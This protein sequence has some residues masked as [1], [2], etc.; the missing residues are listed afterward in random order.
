MTY[1]LRTAALIPWAVGWMAGPWAGLTAVANAQ[2]PSAD[3]PLDAPQS[4]GLFE[5]TLS[6][7]ADA[8]VRSGVA[9]SDNFGADAML[10]VRR[11]GDPSGRR[12]TY[13]KFDLAGV[14]TGVVSATLRVHGHYTSDETVVGMVMLGSDNSWTEDT[15]TWDNRP[16]ATERAQTTTT[17]S[18]VPAW[19]TFDVTSLVRERQ[20]ARLTLV[21]KN[22]TPSPF[23]V[24]LHAHGTPEAPELV[25]SHESPALESFGTGGRSPVSPPQA[26]RPQESQEMPREPE[27]SLRS[28]L[29]TPQG[30]DS[31]R[32]EPANIP[33]TETVGTQHTDEFPQDDLGAVRGGPLVNVTD[34]MG[35]AIGVN[36]GDVSQYADQIQAAGF[37]WVRT[38]L[39]WSAIERPAGVFNWRVAPNYDRIVDE[40]NR[41][42]IGVLYAITLSN[43]IY[44]GLAGKPPYNAAGR[45]NLANF[46]RAAASHYRGRKVIFELGNEPNIRNFWPVDSNG[47]NAVSRNEFIEA[48]QA[49]SDLAQVVVPAMR[50]TG[51]DPDAFVIGPSLAGRG[52]RRFDGQLAAHLYMGKLRDE[53]SLEPLFNR[54]AVHLY[55]AEGTHPRPDMPRGST[56][57]DADIDLYREIIEDPTAN[58][59]NTEQGWRTDGSALENQLQASFNVRD[60]LFG[61]SRGIRFRIWF[62]WD[63]SPGMTRWVI[64][65]KPAARATAV[66]DQELGAFRY[67]RRVPTGNRD[68]Y[69]FEYENSAG[70]K[71]LAAWKARTTAASTYLHPTSRDATV[72]DLLG[73][74]STAR[75][76][77][78]TIT[79]DLDIHPIYVRLR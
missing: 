48:A 50:A 23:K 39:L 28:P 72:V 30:E 11:T 75:S 4:L 8:W 76:N 62:L 37:K 35:V 42:G 67:V 16:A 70:E 1:T 63:G 59:F 66:L 3:A 14:P 13:L 12:E 47:D 79:L 45:R 61:L 51:G 7:I 26:L 20:G 58:M 60:F 68:Q 9:S 52:G 5:T 25:I 49:Y 55:T 34:G 71:R 15:I 33:P 6:P 69:V 27:E 31:G 21:L 57:E 2:Q 38:R 64:R 74:E 56:P 19:H 22:R 46:A 29:Q 32:Q 24:D 54:V 44:P 18:T 78:S 77:G 41:R 17:W 53:G 65:G 10:E 43:G 73:D 36:P 40:F